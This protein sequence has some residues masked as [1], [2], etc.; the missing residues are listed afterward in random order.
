MLINA[1]RQNLNQLSGLLDQL[2]DDNYSSK[3]K[4][5][6]NSS[7]GMHLRHIVEFYQ[8]LAL[9][10]DTGVINYD[11]RN[12][13][14][15]LETDTRYCK[16]QIEEVIGFL[17]RTTTDQVLCLKCD[18]SKNAENKELL[19]IK[20]SLLRELQYNLEHAVHHMALIRIGVNALE[21]EI[22]LHPDFGVAASTIRN[23]ELCAR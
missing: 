14:N 16:Q 19:E 11:E 9:A 22:A 21:N 4:V 17:E 2:S 5:L 12:R 8:C 7:I 18:Y 1:I 13:N 15:L 6:N 23:R 3:L 10:S 20:T